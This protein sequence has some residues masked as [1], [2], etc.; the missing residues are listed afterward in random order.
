MYHSDT[1]SL[2]QHQH[3]ELGKAPCQSSILWWAIF[4]LSCQTYFRGASKIR[5]R[6][7]EG[8]RP[9]VNLTMKVS[10][11]AEPEA[12]IVNTMSCTMK[13]LEHIIFTA[14]RFYQLSSCSLSAPMNR[15]NL[16]KTAVT[17]HPH[18]I[19]FTIP[20]VILKSWSCSSQ[21]VALLY[22]YL[23]KC[24]AMVIIFCRYTHWPLSY[25]GGKDDN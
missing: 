4:C 21:M 18:S 6:R 14:A 19:F 22:S 8:L 17:H 2:N 16:A 7:T 10:L 23:F 20:V 12:T 5:H 13:Y 25:R 15:L 3:E 11:S 1:S 24:V 9:G